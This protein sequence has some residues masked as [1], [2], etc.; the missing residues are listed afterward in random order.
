M[1]YDIFTD[2]H[3]QFRT[4]L[5]KFLAERV[6]PFV[7][8]WEAKREIPRSIWNELGQMGFLG[9]C[10]DPAYGGLGVDPLFRVVMAEELGKCGCL[11]FAVSVAVHNDMSTTYLADLGTDEQKKRWLSPCIEGSSVCA[12]AITDPGAGSD[13]AGIATAAEKKGDAYVLNGQKTFITNGHYADVIV[14]AAK[15]DKKAAPPHRGISLFV[16][17]KG[18]PGLTTQKLEKIGCHASDT[19][20]LFF[21]DV[22]LSADNLLGKEGQGFYALMAKL[23]LERLILAVEGLGAA[24]YVLDKTV[25]YARE[26]KA[27]GKTLT[28][29]QVI[30]HKL[31][32]MATAVGQARAFAY[33]CAGRFA[34]GQD[35]VCEISMLKASVG[36][37]TNRLVYDATQI[38]GGYGYMAEYDVARM[39]GDLRSLSIIGGTTEIMK[40]IIARRMGL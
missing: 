8:E 36:E 22:K 24:Q 10:C 14:V 32:D 9:F 31:A 38:H 26:R 40:E 7:T 21:D 11:G 37:M 2:E 39:Y 5:S 17:E 28:G 15:T 12:I 3:E 27:F 20:E 6:T 34:R 13:V 16:V 25:A 19:A 4:Q 18:T 23:Q 30:R 33:D 35:A 29:I 1:A